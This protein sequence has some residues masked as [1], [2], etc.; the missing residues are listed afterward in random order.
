MKLAIDLSETQQQRLQAIASR[1]NVP[2][3]ALA[4]AAIRELASQ[5]EAEF[6]AVARRLL[7]KNQE[8]YERLG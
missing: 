4:E 8:L 2:V 3:E 6:D 7:A 1:L 5:P